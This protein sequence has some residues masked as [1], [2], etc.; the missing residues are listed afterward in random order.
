MGGSV[1]SM[2][3]Q[4]RSEEVEWTARGGR[5]S[6]QAQ[7][8]EQIFKASECSLNGQSPWAFG[9]FCSCELVSGKVLSL[10]LPGL[11]QYFSSFSHHNPLPTF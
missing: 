6:Q 9:S 3:E 5:N 8:R 7:D 4:S 10:L 1:C 11:E 2:Q